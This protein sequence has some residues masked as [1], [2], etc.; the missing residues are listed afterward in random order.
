MGIGL[1]FLAIASIG[2]YD[3]FVIPLNS[4]EIRC[5][6]GHIKTLNKITSDFLA[7]EKLSLRLDTFRNHG[8]TQYVGQVNNR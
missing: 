3:L 2:L 7:G 1:P 5:R 8:R 4:T 6:A